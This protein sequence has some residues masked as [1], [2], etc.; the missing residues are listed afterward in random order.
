MTLTIRDLGKYR[1]KPD[2]LIVVFNSKMCT[3]FLLLLQINSE[4]LRP[5]TGHGSQTT[6]DSCSSPAI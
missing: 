4:P 2:M 5:K 6:L 3:Q 1:L